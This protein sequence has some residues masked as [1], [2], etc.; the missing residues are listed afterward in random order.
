MQ[1]APFLAFLLAVLAGTP[2]LAQVEGV[3]LLDNESI[4]FVRA[5]DAAVEG[6]PEQFDERQW[7]LQTITNLIDGGAKRAGASAS[8]GVREERDGERRRRRDH[9]HRAGR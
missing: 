6:P 4:G 2:A 5:L 3:P 7:A 8:I 1:R 9:R